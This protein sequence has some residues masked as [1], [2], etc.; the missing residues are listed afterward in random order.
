MPNPTLNRL[1]A[2]RAW[3]NRLVLDWYRGLPGSG[4]EP[5]P[6]PYCFKMLSHI[7]MAEAVWLGRIRGVPAG[8][9]WD[10]LPAEALEPLRLANEAGWEAVQAS[11]TNRVLDYR[12]VN[13]REGRSSVADMILHVCAHGAYHRG[14]VAA[15]AA[16]VGL[17]QIPSTDF[18]LFSRL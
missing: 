16:R 12:L 3:A 2:H 1:Q 9:P 6:D 14:Q 15:Q 13:G 18:I 11:D 5:P 10:V 7:L 4:G 8:G 17:P